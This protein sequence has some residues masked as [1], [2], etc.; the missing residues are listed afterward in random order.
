M[1]NVKNGALREIVID[2][3]LQ[4]RRGYSTKE[5]FDKCNDALEKRGEQPITS[6]N[7]IRNDFIA[8]ENR[9]NIVIEEIR[10]GREIR[11]RYEDRN[12]SIYNTPLNEEEIAQLTQSVSLL[13]RFEGMPG[14]G[15]VDELSAHLQTTVS[16]GSEPV[17][18]F[19]E[20][21]ELKGMRFFTPLF[22]NITSKIAIKIH[23]KNYKSEKTIETVIH[24]YYLKEYNQR[25]FLFALN[26]KYK[27]ISNFALD[28]IEKIESASTKYIPNT[29]IDFT[30]YF[31]NVVGVS[32][33]LGEE[34]QTVKLWIDKEQLPYTLSKPIHK[35]QKLIEKR[36]DGSA[37]ISI[38]VIP[39]FE[40][41]QLLLSFGERVEVLSPEPLRVE[42]S[43]RIKKNHEKYK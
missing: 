2:R 33:T 17:I 9:W 7:T 23:Y 34:V 28:R 15:W 37:V 27:T 12:F 18:G 25:W 11:Y 24:P 26:H 20:N 3:C 29:T 32:V 31:E 5:I 35:S 43:E 16:A 41:K 4:N 40:L 13:R 42:I 8:I 38:E 21:K 10:S 6:Q 36:E 30:H 39:N 1:A 14:F 22:K 19:D